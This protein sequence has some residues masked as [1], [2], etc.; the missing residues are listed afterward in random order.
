M[1]WL[2]LSDDDLFHI[3]TALP[4][5]GARLHK[6]KMEDETPEAQK[7]RDAVPVSDGDLECDDG[8]LVSRGDDPGAYVMCW[9]WIENEQAGIKTEEEDEDEE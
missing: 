3:T 8:A 6:M 2:N 9:K 1:T 7:Y 4:K 5:I